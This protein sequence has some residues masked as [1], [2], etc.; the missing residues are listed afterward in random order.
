MWMMGYNDSGDLN[1]PDSFNGR[2]L[3]PLI[4][5]P[6]SST[7]NSSTISR[8]H[9]AD[10]IALNHHHLGSHFGDQN[11]LREF[12]TPPVVVS[13]R[14]NPTPEQLRTLEELYR[15]G[16]RTPSADQIQ[17]ITAQLR[18]YGKIEGKN[19][20]YWFQNHKARERQKRRRQME[21]SDP[22]HEHDNNSH[23]HHHHHDIEIIERKDAGASR[24]TAGYEAIEQT[25]NNW[26]P[27]STNCSTLAE[28]PV[29]IQRAAKAAALAECRAGG[30]GCGWIQLEEEELH[31]RR[32][33][34]ERNATWQMMQLSCPSS[35]PPINTS[36]T[37]KIPAA[38]A[39]RTLDPTKQFFKTRDLNIFIAPS[40]REYGH[41][42]NH[43]NAL[44]NAEEDGCGGSQTLQ[45]FPLRSGDD[46]ENNLDKGTN[47]SAADIDANL[48]PYQ[49]F[50]FLPLKN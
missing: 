49:F 37:N 21:S 26:P 36:S 40:C 39:I 35:S 25:K 46:S 44:T 33:F 34:V 29:S 30:G 16:T 20:F 8:I 10:I 50:E 48:T 43:L 38:A 3:R 9:G 22:D 14:W 28:E 32:S 1:M 17:H 15:R 12:N 7:N 6:V 31:Q 47:V 19:V 42:F 4:P 2:K 18:R 5:R 11:K 27:S 41:G 23:H 24:T 13:S 45:L